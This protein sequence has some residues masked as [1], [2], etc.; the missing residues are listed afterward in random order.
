MAAAD[1]RDQR[2]A[3]RKS[4]IEAGHKPHVWRKQ[5]RDH[6]LKVLRLNA[7]IAVGNTTISCRTRADMLIRLEI[8][9]IGAMLLGVDHKLDVAIGKELFEAFSDCDGGISRVLDP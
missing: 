3:E 1:S 8:F 7:N 2:P 9:P 5:C 6:G 4:V